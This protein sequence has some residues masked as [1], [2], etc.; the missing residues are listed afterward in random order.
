MRLSNDLYASAFYFKKSITGLTKCSRLS[1]FNPAHV[2]CPSAT[3]VAAFGTFKNKVT[4]PKY[5]SRV[6]LA[7]S[8]RTPSD[9]LF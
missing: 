3:T 2:K 4:A 6:N 5:E 1:A 8:E 9:G 7:A